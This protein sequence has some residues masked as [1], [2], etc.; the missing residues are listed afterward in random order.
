MN[1]ISRKINESILDTDFNDLAHSLVR[2][3]AMA[4]K[5]VAIYTSNHP[6]AEKALGKPFLILERIF[7]VK[8]HVNFNLQQGCLYVLNIRLKDSVFNNEIIKLFQL[9]DVNAIIFDNNL[10]MSDFTLFIDRFTSRVDLANQNNFM[11]KVLKDNN[12]ETIQVNS[13]KCFL[14]FEKSRQYRGDVDGDFSLKQF[15]FDKLGENL[16]FIGEINNCD[17][18]LLEEKNIDFYNDIICYIIP[19]RIA[20]L[21]YQYLR[22]ELENL[23]SKINDARDNREK[24]SNLTETYLSV[25]KLV[26][27]HPEREKIIENLDAVSVNIS[28]KDKK[29]EGSPSQ[30]DAIRIETR[31]HVDYILASVFSP[32][33]A[34]YDLD[35][36]S[37]AVRRLLKTGQRGKAIDVNRQLLDYLE[38]TQTA[39]RQRSLELFWCF[40]KQSNL[41]DDLKVI[42]DVINRIICRLTENRE[43]FEYSEVIWCLLEKFLIS[44]RYDLMNKL[45][46]GIA[47]RRKINNG[48]TI[49]DSI[50]I[51]K[52]FS[53]INRPEIIKAMIDDMVKSRYQESTYI[54]DI[55]IALGTEEV[56]LELSNIIS[57]PIRQVRQQALKILS[58]LGKASLKIFSQ[59]LMDDAMFERDSDRYELPDNKWYIVRNSIFVL[60]SLG[61]VEALNSLRLRI[62]DLDIRVRREIIR[63]LEKIGGEESCDL[64]TVMADDPV[65]EIRE[66]AVITVGLI[67]T[68]D[69]VPLVIDIIR[70]NPQIALKAINALSKIGGQD[71]ND[72][73]V[74]LLE[75][76]EQFIAVKGSYISKD[77]L[78]LAVVKA[79]GKIGD[80]Q[81]LGKIKKIKDNMST[82]QK[83]FFKNSPLNK[84]ISDILSRSK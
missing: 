3:L 78:R 5:K 23:V 83:I 47:I 64:L 72:F 13:E 49:Y 84:E 2:E 8:K 58:E 1:K 56:A 43:T 38:S 37:D 26:D 40:I 11:S 21:P 69:V 25:F 6:L 36:F 52:V 63:S 62:N 71:A 59:I 61:D 54:R 79:L 14:M 45:I 57:H 74:R 27:Y 68:P 17:E 81:S 44:K 31:E 15:V 32:G 10:T 42:E 24:L 50:A 46:V 65:Q 35:D 73:L 60:G 39:Y 66:A 20:S 53:Y 9:Q 7:R 41:T 34:V 28:S 19:E 75:D 55:L 67:G 12:I 51:K 33:G 22:K 80:K 18:K 4:C 82:T 70:K 16:P 30:V 48:I 29:S 77:D 76:D